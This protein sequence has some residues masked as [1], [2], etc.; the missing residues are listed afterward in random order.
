MFKKSV[1]SFTRKAIGT[2]AVAAAT[3][4]LISLAT[5]LLGGKTMVGASPDR[6]E[7]VVDGNGRK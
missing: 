7:I 3:L 6:I 2:T 4:V 5:L 1:R